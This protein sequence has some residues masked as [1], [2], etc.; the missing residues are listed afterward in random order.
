M[1]PDY[2]C[3]FRVQWKRAY[4][5][6]VRVTFGR[7]ALSYLALFFKCCAG[8]DK[9]PKHSLSGSPLQWLSH[10]IAPPSSVFSYLDTSLSDD[11]TG[12]LSTS[13]E[14]LC[15][16]VNTNNLLVSLHMEKL[17][18]KNILLIFLSMSHFIKHMLL[19]LLGHLNF[20]HLRHLFLFA[21]TTLSFLDTVTLH[22]SSK[23]YLH[24]PT[25]GIESLSFMKHLS[26]L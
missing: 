4:Y 20:C 8:F 19:S 11:N 22:S 15:I 3:Y 21:S 12:D 5:F 6:V 13:L 7:T 24:L 25:M 10:Y 17:N 9:Q 26:E 16:R 18:P 1:R 14:F 23:A 2:W